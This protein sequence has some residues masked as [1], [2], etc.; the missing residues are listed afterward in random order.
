MTGAL[1]VAPGVDSGERR[2]A[3][4]FDT[5]G[6]ELRKPGGE[7]GVKLDQPGLI[8]N[9][10]RAKEERGR[11][12]FRRGAGRA[13]TGELAPALLIWN[14]EAFGNRLFADFNAGLAAPRF[15]PTVASGQG[16]GEGEDSNSSAHREAKV[17]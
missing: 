11:V 4:K 7:P 14:A 2:L 1:L 12:G 13:V 6:D 10:R 16:E 15:I 9:V 17:A 5:E 3:V 8:A